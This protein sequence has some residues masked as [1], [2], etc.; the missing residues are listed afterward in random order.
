[1][2]ITHKKQLAIF[3]LSH[4]IIDFVCFYVLMGSFSGGVKNIALIS[5]GFLIYNFIAFALQVPIG[6]LADSCNIPYVYFAV[7]GC[8]LVAAGATPPLFSWIKLLLCAFGN[9]FFHVGGGIDSLVHADGKFARSGIFIAFGAVGVSL[10]TLAAT[11]G[12]LS[13]WAVMLLPLVCIITLLFCR[14]NHFSLGTFF[15]F[16]PSY[17]KGTDFVI[18]ISAIGIIIRAIVGAYMP[19]PWKST[20]FLT[21]LPSICVFAGKFFGGF[22]ADR[23]GARR[24]TVVSLL[25]SAPLLSFFTGNILLCCAGLFFFNVTTSVTLCVIVSK[26]PNN[27]GFGFGITTL[28]LFTGTAFS[29]FVAMSPVMRPY[30]LLAFILIAVACMLL[31]ASDKRRNIDDTAV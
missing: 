9:A 17:I 5:V 13:A 14:Q 23:F 28:A 6:Y 30:L 24:V 11:S 1:M 22:L 26:L 2:H 21:V 7:F 15:D 27:P 4:L 3:S 31:T 16:A 19:V 10:G 8:F 18:Y 25:I 12:L 20:V 29:F